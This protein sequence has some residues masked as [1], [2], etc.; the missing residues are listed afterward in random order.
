MARKSP[1]P[2]K[3][4]PNK[5]LRLSIPVMTGGHAAESSVYKSEVHAKSDALA[6]ATATMTISYHHS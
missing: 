5:R 3:G 4:C 1:R 2:R 6:V